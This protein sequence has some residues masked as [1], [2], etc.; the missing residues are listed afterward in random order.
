MSLKTSTDRTITK[1][2]RIIVRSLYNTNMYTFL[3][4]NQAKD[5]T[6]NRH[7]QHSSTTMTFTSTVPMSNMDMII[8]QVLSLKRFVPDTLYLPLTRHRQNKTTIPFISEPFFNTTV[9]NQMSQ[10]LLTLFDNKA[11]IISIF[12]LQIQAQLCNKTRDRHQIFEVIFCTL[13]NL[14]TAFKILSKW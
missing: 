9:F 3:V 12:L 8:Q 14:I 10:L 1:R 11:S 4:C 5:H 6:H 2:D 13:V 7:Q